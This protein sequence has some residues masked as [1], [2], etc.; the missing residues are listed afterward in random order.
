MTL[1]T[2]TEWQPLS[3]APS[4]R[5][6]FAPFTVPDALCW[7]PRSRTSSFLQASRS[8]A[9]WEKKH[10]EFLGIKLLRTRDLRGVC[11]SRII[12]NASSP[13]AHPVLPRELPVCNLGDKAKEPELAQICPCPLESNKT[14]APVKFP[15][16][17]PGRCLEGK[18]QHQ[19]EKWLRLP[20]SE[21]QRLPANPTSAALAIATASSSVSNLPKLR[22]VIS[23]IC[24]GE[25]RKPLPFFLICSQIMARGRSIFINFCSKI[26]SRLLKAL[27]NEVVSDYLLEIFWMVFLIVT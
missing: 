14:S 22:G 4:A 20:P 19:F 13:I 25:Q 11:V 10:L 7:C 5:A 15:S 6:V 21:D 12:C 16:Q 23:K 8:Q 17:N 18:P 24:K 1:S 27:S 3:E 2:L 9:K 26:S